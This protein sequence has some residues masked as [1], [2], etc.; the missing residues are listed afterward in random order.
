MK[1]FFVTNLET[2]PERSEERSDQRSNQKK[3][4]ETFVDF[5]MEQEE[6]C[7]MDTELEDYLSLLII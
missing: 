4:K 3:F 5:F 7:E 2:I 1:Q 6:P